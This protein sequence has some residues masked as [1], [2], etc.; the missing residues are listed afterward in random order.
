M[1]EQEKNDEEY[2]ICLAPKPSRKNKKQKKSEIT[3]VSL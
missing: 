2:M 1:S 3:G